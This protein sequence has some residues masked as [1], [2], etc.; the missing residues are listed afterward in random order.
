M[1]SNKEGAQTSIYLASSEEVRNT[2]GQYFKNKKASTPS[3]IARDM[4]AA[5]K[6]WEISN[7][8]CGL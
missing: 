3:R 8:L 6:L 4:D 2:S 1:T 7:K 5:K